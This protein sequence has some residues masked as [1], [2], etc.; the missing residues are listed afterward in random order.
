M[1]CCSCDCNSFL[2]ST[3][4]C[5]NYANDGKVGGTEIIFSV[6]SASL[7]LVIFIIILFFGRKNN[8]WVLGIAIVVSMFIVAVLKSILK[9]PRPFQTICKNLKCPQKSK[10]CNSGSGMPSGHSSAITIIGIIGIYILYKQF[11][12]SKITLGLSML[13]L[14]YCV[15]VIYSRHYLK[16]HSVKQIG[17]GMTIGLLI[18]IIGCFYI[19]QVGQISWTRKY[20]AMIVAIIAMTVA[21]VKNSGA[22]AIGGIIS[23]YAVPL[24]ISFISCVLVGHIKVGGFIPPNIGIEMTYTKVPK[25][26]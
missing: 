2:K 25:E 3:E 11:G 10:L 15:T 23:V 14:A 5:P 13:L 18:G 9:E 4:S 7:F 12:R 1:N 17:A 6:F 22:K 21:V 16:Y 24:L 26:E 8:I 19:S 20:V